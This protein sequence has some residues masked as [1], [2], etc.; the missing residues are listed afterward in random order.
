MTNHELQLKVIRLRRRIFQITLAVNVVLTVIAAKAAD[1][2]SLRVLVKP[3]TAE[4][5]V[6]EPFKVA[7]RVENPTTTNQ[8]V[9]VM[10]CSWDEHWKSSNTNVSWLG[11][12]CSKNFAVNVAIPPNGAYTNQLEMLV[13]DAARTGATS[14]RMGFTPVDCAT[15]FWSDE[16][17]LNILPPDTRA[18]DSAI[19]Q[20]LG[21]WRESDSTNT[22]E[23]QS[24]TAILG[25]I[26]KLDYTVR[27]AKL[28]FQTPDN[29]VI[30]KL[31]M[32][33]HTNRTVVKELRSRNEPP[34]HDL[35]VPFHATSQELE[36]TW[37][38]R[39]RKYVRVS[40]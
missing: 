32:E 29:I 12:N 8:T 4:V 23:F 2:N 24:Q 31:A 28:V 7:L 33:V 40:E 3:S 6:K 18:S 30:E 25:P 9:R 36:I 34:F 35:I 17:Q 22:I 38:D 21:T 10:N 19:K 13:L 5:R 11:W 39:A 37:N 14:F 15:T 26:L 1:A 27:G 16:V 20:L